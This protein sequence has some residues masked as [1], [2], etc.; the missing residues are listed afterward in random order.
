LV[1]AH[2]YRA[3]VQYSESG[4]VVTGITEIG[5]VPNQFH[6]AQ[7]FPNPFN[8]STTIRWSLPRDADVR[9]TIYN[10]LGQPVRTLVNGRREAGRH[11]AAWDGL[12]DRFIPV[13]SGVYLMQ[14]I[15]PDNTA[16]RKM[17]LLR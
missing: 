2:K 1:D 12:N 17:L 8:P 4:G 3:L 7:N 9:L 5:S 11:Q 6:L 10:L 16:T 14:L 15:T 13:A